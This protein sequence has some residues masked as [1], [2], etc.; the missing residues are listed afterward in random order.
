[1]N[2]QILSRSERRMERK[3]VVILLV[4]VLAVA[5]VSF[6][7]GVMTGRSGSGRLMARE[8][9]IPIPPRIPIGKVPSPASAA[10]DVRALTPA[11]PAAA[12]PGVNNLTFYDNLP[13]GEQPPLGSGINLPPRENA[14]LDPSAS[15]MP[16]AIPAVP[17]AT[18]TL[19]AA[20]AA[21]VAP[22][23]AP[24]LKVATKTA[25]KPSAAASVKSESFQVQVAS[26]PRADEAGVLQERLTKKGYEVYVQQVDLGKKGLWYRVNVGP[27]PS[28]DSAQKTADRLK[29]EGK[30]SPIVRKR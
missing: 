29:A 24:A 16:P 13:R 8:E 4:M 14:P 6:A 17:A 1:M 18:D 23:A 25:A 15:V 22:S 11:A 2:R 3:Q 28:A 7:L 19:P 10:P 9:S 20:P 26:F 12:G 21:A 5:L 27:L 30:F